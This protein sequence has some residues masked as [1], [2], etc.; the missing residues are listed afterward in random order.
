MYLAKSILLERF[1]FL[2]LFHNPVTRIQ[3]FCMSL[4]L[5]G[6]AHQSPRTSQMAGGRCGGSFPR[7]A[8]GAAEE[9][10]GSRRDVLNA[11]RDGGFASPRTDM[12]R[13][14]SPSVID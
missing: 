6:H 14:V 12:S 8:P 9:Y 2:F 3:P 13:T 4:I 1:F 7:P 10:P 5:L 11:E